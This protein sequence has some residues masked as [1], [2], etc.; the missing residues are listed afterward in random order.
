VFWQ[1]AVWLAVDQEL[2][3]FSVYTKKSVVMV[4]YGPMAVSFMR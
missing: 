2:V 4:S 3:K 1:Q